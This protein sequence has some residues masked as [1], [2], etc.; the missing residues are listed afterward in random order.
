MS[1]DIKINL[2]VETRSLAIKYK[3]RRL[4]IFFGP[5]G[6]P[7]SLTDTIVGESRIEGD[8]VVSTSKSVYKLV[9]DKAHTKHVRTITDL[10]LEIIK[11]IAGL[12]SDIVLDEIESSDE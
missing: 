10:N 11:E 1:K 7:R 3:D 12:M 4:K 2:Y 6:M 9:S 5:D 8:R